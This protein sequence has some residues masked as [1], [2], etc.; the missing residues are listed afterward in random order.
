MSWASRP[1]RSGSRSRRPP[2][3]PS[4][5]GPG[6]AT[7][8]P[9]WQRETGRSPTPTCWS[10]AS[11]FVVLT[12]A[13]GLLLAVLIDQ[14]IRGE[15][16]LAHDLPL[17]AGGF[18]RRHR[19]GL[20]LAAQ[21]RPRHPEARARPRLDRLPLRLDHRPRLR[22]LHHRHRRRLAGLGLRHGAVPGRPALGR[23]RSDQG[24]ADRRRRAA[25]APT[26]ASSC[27]RIAPIFIAVLRD[28]AAVRHQDL[29][30]GAWR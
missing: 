8:P 21:P 6:C 28:P 29:R 19:H 30:S 20:A 26:C 4:T 17:S 7:T 3:C 13:L 18:L 22:D 25:A 23:S 27:R 15:N 12:M 16:V 2:C 11:A 1:R 14:R 10:T 9:C 5:T 24:G